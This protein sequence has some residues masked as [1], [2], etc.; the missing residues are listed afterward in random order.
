MVSTHG[1]GVKKEA[2]GRSVNIII[3]YKITVCQF[4]TKSIVK[5]QVN[6]KIK[7]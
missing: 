6:K 1:K 5:R 7:I 4:W 2:C 3:K